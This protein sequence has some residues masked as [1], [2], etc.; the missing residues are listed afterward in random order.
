MKIFN[1]SQLLLE[2][3]ETFEKTGTKNKGM[4]QYLV[5]FRVLVLAFAWEKYRF[6]KIVGTFV[7]IRTRFPT[8]T[9]VRHIVVEGS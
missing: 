4:K 9:E 7:K 2:L 8:N 6:T 1:V 5:H 3:K